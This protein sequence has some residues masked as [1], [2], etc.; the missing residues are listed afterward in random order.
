MLS[1]TGER[2]VSGGR[3][4]AIPVAARAQNLVPHA[5]RASTATIH[6]RWR[7]PSACTSPAWRLRRSQRTSSR[8]SRPSARSS[9]T[10]VGSG[11]M[12]TVC[13]SSRGRGEDPADPDCGRTGF[14]RTF[15]FVTLE[16]TPA[17][18]AK[19]ASALRFSCWT[20]DGCSRGCAG[21]SML[22]GSMWKGHKLRIAIAKPDYMTQCVLLTAHFAH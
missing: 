1:F 15:A 4:P 2:S 16:T 3:P 22:S 13:A 8:G 18:L 12:Q 7:Q 21:T 14:P 5:V 10:S 11:S 20:S 6:Q 17:K 19:C 9:A